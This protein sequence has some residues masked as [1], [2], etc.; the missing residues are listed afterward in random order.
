MTRPRS[1]TQVIFAAVTHDFRHPGVSNTFMLSVSDVSDEALKHSRRR[2]SRGSMGS[3]ESQAVAE[4]LSPRN[5]ILKYQE[6]ALMYNDTSVLENMHAAEAFR[7][8]NKVRI[9]C[10]RARRHNSLTL[11][12]PR[13]PP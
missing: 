7:L 2:K 13:S 1:S 8:L 11:R 9:V 3:S 5:N 10:S 12:A 4:L 6:L